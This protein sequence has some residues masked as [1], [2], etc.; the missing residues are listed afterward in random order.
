MAA[1]VITPLFGERGWCLGLRLWA[2]RPSPP[3]PPLLKGGGKAK[4]E[5]AEL[6]S[7]G[8]AALHLEVFFCFFFCLALLGL[9]QGH[10][11]IRVP[12]FRV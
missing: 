7:S 9:G 11:M 8:A 1:R 5:G 3:P 4:G 6:I 10:F 2:G 12:G